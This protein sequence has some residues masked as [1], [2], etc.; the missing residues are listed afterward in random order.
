MQSFTG[1]T[2]EAQ[3]WRAAQQQQHQ[4]QAP[5]IMV[6]TSING[7]FTAAA[8][9]AAATQQRLAAHA[10]ETMT[11]WLAELRSTL[12]SG[13]PF[14]ALSRAGPSSGAFVR[15]YV[16][17]KKALLGSGDQYH[18]YLEEGDL[19]LMSALHYSRQGGSRFLLATDPSDL[20]KSR[21]TCVGKVGAGWRGDGWCRA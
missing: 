15:C 14:A 5:A 19:Y 7:S 12:A 2:D 20:D 13:Q 18:L 17:R 9:G 21:S 6:A 3:A 1:G 10:P 16:K 11:S 4:P 8:A